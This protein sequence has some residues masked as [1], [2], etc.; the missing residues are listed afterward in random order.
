MKKILILTVIALLA[1]GG[2]Q[3]QTKPQATKTT[4][5]AMGTNVTAATANKLS[6]IQ[7]PQ[8][9]V[10]MDAPLVETMR[11]RKTSRNFIEDKLDMEMTSSLLWCAYGI[12]REE[13]GLRVV[14]SAMNMQEYEIYLFNREGIYLYNAE[15]NALQPIMAGDYREKIS[16]QKHFAVAPVSI[17]IVANYDKMQRIKDTADRDFYAAVDC[18]YI[19]QNIYLFCASANLGTVA[20]GGINRDDL[21]KM[22]K[23][24][25]GR[26]MLAHPVGFAK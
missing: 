23:I 11:N 2:L 19:S 1:L 20:C 22:L 4:Q 7:L 15:K 21:A 10:G 17:V 12:N 13:K 16:S 25:N 14:P 8:P 9:Q 24:K 26:V 5:N 6:V 18:G 3:A